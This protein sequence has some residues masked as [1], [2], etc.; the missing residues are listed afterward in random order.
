ME[1]LKEF[2]KTAGRV[3]FSAGRG[4]WNTLQDY[5]FMPWHIEEKAYARGEYERMKKLEDENG[6]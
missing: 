5:H 3:V 6:L 4:E 1:G 2:I